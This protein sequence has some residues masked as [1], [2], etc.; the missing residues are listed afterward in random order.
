MIIDA[1]NQFVNPRGRVDSAGNVKKITAAIGI[2]VHHTVTQTMAEDA[3]Q[4]EELATLHVIEDY[5]VSIGYQLF[6]YHL[7]AFPSG[8]VYQVGDLDG[9][10]AHVAGRNHEL[11]GVVA[12]GTF[13]TVAPSALQLQ[14]IA[15]GIRLIQARMGDWLAVKGHGVWALPGEGTACAGA[16]MNSLDSADWQRLVNSPAP[17]PPGGTDVLNPYAASANP[18][19]F[20]DEFTDPVRVW[21]TS[22][23]QDDLHV[24]AEAKSVEVCA[25]VAAG[26]LDLYH[27]DGRGKAGYCP[28]GVHHYRV[29]LG[30]DEHRT[31][32][33]RPVGF[34][35]ILRIEVLGW[36]AS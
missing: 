7:A 30:A 35:D 2:A 4:A 24:P 28:A 8:R 26:G 11:V 32:E 21:T 36:Y 15:E 20:A 33:I 22:P 27:G 12:V 34:A 29:Y 18:P 10:R 25:Y 31:F 6:A 23:V 17:T 1:R 5:H 9:Q 19:F 13:T 3:T 16:Y 14:A